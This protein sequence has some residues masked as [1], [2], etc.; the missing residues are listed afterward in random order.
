MRHEEAAA[1]R[2]G[3]KLILP[4]ALLCAQGVAVQETFI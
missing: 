4:G 1:L 3:L 2:R